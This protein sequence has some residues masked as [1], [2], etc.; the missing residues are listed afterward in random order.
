MVQKAA[1][2]GVSILI[3]V[4]APTALAIRLADD[5]GITLVGFAREHSHVIYTHPKRIV[6]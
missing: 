6:P 4:S 3:A 2:V 1:T 5:C